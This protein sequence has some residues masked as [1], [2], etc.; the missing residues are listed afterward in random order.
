MATIAGSSEHESADTD[1]CLGAGHAWTREGVIPTHVIH[2]DLWRESEATLEGA[3]AVVMLHSV[4][5]ED[6]YLSIVA[7]YVQLYM[8]LP[9]GCQL[10]HR[11]SN[12]C[13]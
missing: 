12:Q 7:H 10:R 13:R 2:G 5:V 3:P 1:T 8:Y 6:L 9:L 11:I 4:G